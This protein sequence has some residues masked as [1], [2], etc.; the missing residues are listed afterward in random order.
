MVCLSLFAFSASCAC[1]SLSDSTTGVGSVTTGAASGVSITSNV[2]ASS[3]PWEKAIQAIASS[4]K[5]PVMFAI[6]ILMFAAAVWGVIRGA[7]L[8]SWVAP[9]AIMGLAVAAAA[10][11]DKVLNFIGVSGSMYY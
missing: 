9:M 10:N 2:G 5:G 7:E 4:V 8:S 11:A 3:A 1:A 6:G